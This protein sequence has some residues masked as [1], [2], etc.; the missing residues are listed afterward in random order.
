MTF[1]VRYQF[2]TY[3]GTRTVHARDDD[4]AIAKVR[5][6]VR[7]QSSLTLAYESYKVIRAVENT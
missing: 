4:E 3:S 7:S 5:A 1:D 6:W 2:A